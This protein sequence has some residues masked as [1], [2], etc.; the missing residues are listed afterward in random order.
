VPYVF[1]ESVLSK[2]QR[3][4]IRGFETVQEQIRAARIYMD[5]RGITRPSTPWL[6]PEFVNPLFLRS[7]CL[8]LQRDGKSEF[9]RGLTGTKEIFAFYLKSVA[10]NLGVDRDGSDDLIP[11]VTGTLCAISKEM[12]SNRKDYISRASATNIA[13]QH[14]QAFSAPAHRKRSVRSACR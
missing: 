5:R 12:A 7:T 13:S 4:T 9:P 14:F 3:I 2:T 1:P 10:R 11:A 8:A 6:A